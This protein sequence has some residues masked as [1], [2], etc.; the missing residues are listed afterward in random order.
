MI[1]ARRDM[2]IASVIEPKEALSAGGIVTGVVN[3]T[4]SIVEATVISVG[5]LIDDVVEG[6]IIGY[7]KYGGVLFEE[8]GVTYVAIRSK[9]IIGYR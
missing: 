2:V 4:S 9:D 7:G 1:K 6:D 3:N 8:H 5:P